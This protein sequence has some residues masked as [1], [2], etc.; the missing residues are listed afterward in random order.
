MTGRGRSKAKKKFIKI[1]NDAN[2]DGALI[3]DNILEHN[4]V[5][6]PLEDVKLFQTPTGQGQTTLTPTKQG[7]EKA[8]QIPPE[9][10]DKLDEAGLVERNVEGL[11]NSSIINTKRRVKL[12]N[13][14]DRFGNQAQA[15]E[16]KD[17]ESGRINDIFD[18]LQNKYRPFSSK[19]IGKL[20]KPVYQL[21]LL[22]IFLLF[23]WR[24]LQLY[25]NLL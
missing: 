10:V 15:L 22:V 2:L 5:F 8:R 13:I 1:L 9:V 17:F 20:A 11:V 16:L 4:G 21:I 19:A 14:K 23:R 24:R 7:F 18:S 12:Q 6:T 3:L 25:Q